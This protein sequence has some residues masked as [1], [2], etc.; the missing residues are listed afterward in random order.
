MIKILIE[1]ETRQVNLGKGFLGNDKE[2]LQETLE[3]SFDEFVDGQARLEIMFPNE[4]KTFVTLDKVE[5]TYTMPV[6]NV[7]TQKGKVDCQLV[8]TEGTEQESVPLFKSNIFY[9]YVGESIN[10]E[11][12]DPEPYI[13]WIDKADTKLNQVD[14]LDIEAEKEGTIT[15]ITITKKDGTQ[16]TVEL[17]DGQKGDTGEQGIQGIQGEKGD[18]G[19]K[20]DTGDSYVL[21]DADKQ[22]IADIVLTDFVDGDEVSF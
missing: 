16:Q 1:K 15:T 13:E 10:A 5:E 3:F 4:E 2:N 7:M 20:G 19:D 9:F 22:E 12:G 14:N 6:T 21:T 8:V 17:I 18:K 11:T